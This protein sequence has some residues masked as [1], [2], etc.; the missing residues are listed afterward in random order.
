MPGLPTLLPKARAK[1]VRE[2]PYDES[3]QN[4]DPTTARDERSEFK[5]DQNW[6][7]EAERELQVALKTIPESEPLA[8]LPLMTEQEYEL[9]KLEVRQYKGTINLWLAADFE[10]AV[11][12]NVLTL[13]DQILSKYLQGKKLMPRSFKLIRRE[14]V[15]RIARTFDAK[16]IDELANSYDELRI[17]LDKD[18]KKLIL[19]SRL[20]CDQRKRLFKD[21][22]ET[23][24][25]KREWSLLH[26]FDDLTSNAMTE[27]IKACKAAKANGLGSLDKEARLLILSAGATDFFKK[28]LESGK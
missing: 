14:A 7:E 8:K 6:R 19:D 26:P 28:L 13:S 1:S 20:P 11:A 16:K 3:Q 18:A 22:A 12:L 24:G 25:D 4:P 17:L 2:I 23:T 5:K 27:A 21:Y 15:V 9:A 10:N